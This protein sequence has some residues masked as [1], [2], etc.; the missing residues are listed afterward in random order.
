MRSVTI[1]QELVYWNTQH[2]STH[3]ALYVC[4]G[5][6]S[7]N[8]VYGLIDNSEHAVAEISRFSMF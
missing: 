8:A 3:L 7:Y 6:Y 2:L 1:T 4:S 5:A